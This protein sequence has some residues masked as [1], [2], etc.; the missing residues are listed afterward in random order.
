MIE[1]AGEIAVE[2][3]VEGLV[4]PG[5]RPVLLFGIELGGPGQDEVRPLLGRDHERGLEV[6]LVEEL[7]VDAEGRDLEPEL[8]ER[9]GQPG[10]GGV[11]GPGLPLA[12]TEAEGLEEGR[13][14]LAPAA[15]V[16]FGQALDGEGLGRR[17]PAA[18]SIGLV[19]RLL[20]GR[21]RPLRHGRAGLVLALGIIS[22]WLG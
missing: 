17:L 4:Q 21:D 20:P 14:G 1:A 12:E 11:R 9:R 16:R 10:E 3:P 22:A 2:E 18:F 15:E 13:F 5:Q 8:F 19:D 7:G 6:G